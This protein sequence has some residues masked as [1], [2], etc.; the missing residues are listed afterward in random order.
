MD[1]T[2]DWSDQDVD[3]NGDGENSSGNEGVD[4]SSSS[5]SR[6]RGSGSQRAA[7]AA[8]GPVGEQLL[9][10][11]QAASSGADSGKMQTAETAAGS[12]DDGAED[13]L[14]TEITP[15]N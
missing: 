12:S 6:K 13:A 9:D 7:L 8:L 1:G 3:S 11:N 14:K 15:E 10:E 5:N 4:G 2:E